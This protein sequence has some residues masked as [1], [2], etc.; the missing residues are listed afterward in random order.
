MAQVV[1]GTEKIVWYSSCITIITVALNP[2]ISQAADYWGRKPIIIASSLIGVIGSIIVSRAKNSGTIIAG[3]GILG[4]NFGCQS[5]VMAVLSEVLPRYYRPMAQASAG[6]AA[7]VGAIIGL[8]M[9]GGLLQHGNLTNYRIYWYVEAGLYAIAALGCLIAYNPPHREL[10]VSLSTS[11][12]L[13]R[14]DWVGYFLFAPGLVLFSM[15][16]SWSNNP[17]SWSSANILGP[18][19]IGIVAMILFVVYEWRFKKDGILHHDLWQ[20]RNFA[21]SLLVIFVE[22]VS[23]F[24][25]NSYYTYE[26]MVIYDVNILSGGTNFAIMFLTGLVL[27]PVIGLWSSKRKEM[28]PPLILGSVFL[29]LFFIL[30]ATVKIDNP[31]YAFWI[32]PILPG[33]AVVSVVPIAMVSAQLTAS[34]E[35]ITLASALVTA[36]RSLGGAIGLAINNAVFNGTLNRELPKKVGAAALSLGL[37]SSSLAEL[38]TALASQSTNAVAKVPG[39][40]PE[41]AQAA[42]AAMKRAYLDAFRGAW[43]VSAAFCAVL[44][45]CESALPMSVSK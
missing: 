34:P 37:P 22:G 33:I 45:I 14:L 16:L 2:P 32:F 3:F 25:A 39:V 35:L 12:K 17:Y 28:R 18:F 7:S 40:T 15:A 9:G 31:R 21:V 1:G 38:M 30:L 44:V 43:I 13:N 4:L 26:L 27:S 36:V 10:E 42:V 6:I 41:I 23:F 20:N 5:V 8:L 29:L 19:S 24:A 11:E